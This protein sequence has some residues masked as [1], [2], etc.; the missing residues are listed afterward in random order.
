[1]KTLYAL[2][3]VT[4][5]ADDGEIEDAFSRLK[6][7]YPDSRLASDDNAR[8]Q[9]QGI[10]Q[11]Y[12]VLSNPAARRMYDARLARAGVKT[13]PVPARGMDD[14]ESPGLLTTRN[15][16]VAGLFVIAVAGMWFYHVR[17]E[18]R[19][20]KEILE[21]ALKMEEEQRAR[22]AAQ[23]EA[24]E[25][26]RQAAQARLDKRQDEMREQQLRNDATRSMREAQQQSAMAQRQAMYEQ[27]NRERQERQDQVAKQRAAFEAQQRINN[28]KQQ[29]RQICMQRYNRPDC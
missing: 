7:R 17:E 24:D 2:L 9:F 3:G 13:A 25:Q 15:I 6:M 8:I 18:T 12:N 10:Q 28:D 5:D 4:P 19:L 22:V 29:L 26:R 11:A 16:I 27:Q 20:K 23:Q 1:M 21:R 14:D